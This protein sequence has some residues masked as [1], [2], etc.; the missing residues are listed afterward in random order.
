MQD[1]YNNSRI[2]KVKSSDEFRTLVNSKSFRVTVV[3][4]SS[5]NCGAC[6]YMKYSI[7]IF[8]L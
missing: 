6:V 5:T 2:V 3:N 7:F 4:F 1:C 8:F